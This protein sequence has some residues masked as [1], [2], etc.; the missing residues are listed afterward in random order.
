MT[1]IFCV[2]SA[3][4][5]SDSRRRE[6]SDVPLC[7][8]EKAVVQRARG[9]ICISIPWGLWNP[10]QLIYATH[11]GIWFLRHVEN[12]MKWCQF[13]LIESERGKKRKASVDC[14]DKICSNARTASKE[15]NKF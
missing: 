1:W 8:K 13:P 12:D 9:I 3:I 7:H 2:A 6:G 4:R 15:V 14:S 5:S 10:Q 11:L